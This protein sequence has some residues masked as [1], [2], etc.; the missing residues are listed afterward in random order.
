MI[1][2]IIL[3][4]AGSIGGG[5]G[6]W[7]FGRRQKNAEAVSAELGNV[8]MIIRMWQESAEAF[9]N[10]S[11]EMKRENEKINEQLEEIKKENRELHKQIN[12]IQVTVTTLRCEN[13][14]LVRRLNEIKALQ[15]GN[16]QQR[17]EGN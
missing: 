11:D 9:K 14:G 17:T 6:G 3:I 8:Q 10:A 15:N 12:E 7:V 13:K 1:E 2:Q 4:V 5:V 16:K